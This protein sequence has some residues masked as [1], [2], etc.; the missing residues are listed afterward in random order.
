MI[1]ATPLPTVPATLAGLRVMVLEDDPF[2]SILL[3]DMLADLGFAVVGPFGELDT[4]ERFIR[5]H[6]D[7]ID[8]AIL[9]VNIHGELSF[10]LAEMLLQRNVPFFFSTG[11]T[12]ARMP[13]RWRMWPNIGKLFTETGLLAM[14]AESCG[15]PVGRPDDDFATNAFVVK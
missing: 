2:C 6:A 5:D 14:I 9:D 3:E 12:Q 7:M 4:A 1:H 13:L 8:V 11:Y 10:G 15:L